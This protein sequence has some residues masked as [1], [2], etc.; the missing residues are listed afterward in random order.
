MAVCI[1]Q[2]YYDDAQRPAL[3]PAFLPYDNR[4]NP[5]PEWREYHV[6]RTEWLAGRCRA[7]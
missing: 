7:G 5:R 2:I 6:F 4:A 3:D 1:H